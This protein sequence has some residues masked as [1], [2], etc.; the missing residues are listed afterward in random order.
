MPLAYAIGLLMFILLYNYYSNVIYIII[1]ICTFTSAWNH[2]FFLNIVVYF[3]MCIYMSC[4]CVA[5]MSVLACLC[6]HA[7]QLLSWK[8]QCIIKEDGILNII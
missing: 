1:L 7:A 5:K 8:I 2:I 6:N 3:S 4:S